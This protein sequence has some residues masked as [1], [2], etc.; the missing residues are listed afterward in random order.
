MINDL[1][2]TFGANVLP[3]QYNRQ[4]RWTVSE[5]ERKLLTAVLMDAIQCYLSN[6]KAK[7]RRHRIEF[8]EA[9]RWFERRGSAG[10]GLFAFE[11]L[12]E[13]LGLNPDALRKRLLTMPPDGMRPMRGE[14]RHRAASAPARVMDFARASA[15]R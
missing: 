15:A 10:Q 2:E 9:Q 11:T 3:A 1:L 7:D 13:A 6:R 5:N 4:P 14:R 12:C 8:L